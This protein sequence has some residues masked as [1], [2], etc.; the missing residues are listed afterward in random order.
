MNK[1]FTKEEIK[2]TIKY[3]KNNKSTG[4]DG[5]KAELL[6]HAPEI[7]C[8][9]IAEIAEIFNEAAKSGDYP[10]EL[11]Q[12]ILTKIQKR[13]KTKGPITNLRPITLLRKILASCMKQR[14]IDRIDREIPPSQTAYRAGRSTTEHVFAMKI[15]A[16]K[17]ITSQEYTIF[18]LILD[19]SKAFD[20]VNR[21]LLI[22]DLSKIIKRDELHIISIMLQV[23]LSVKCGSSTSEFFKTDTGVPQ[24]DGLSANQ[25]TL[26][27]ANT[28]KNIQRNEN[29]YAIQQ[30]LT[31]TQ[32]M[33]CRNIRG[34][35]CIFRCQS[36]SILD[37]DTINFC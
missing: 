29:D 12:G 33:H 9:E 11:T 34:I 10:K 26:Y 14:I 23:E 18:L 35:I 8:T 7:V 6:K 13:G 31:L 17:T 30:P 16:E 4:N 32:I 20:T 37:I 28:L 19:M 22:E 25:F 2:N 27:L 36:I 5:V 1:P 3:L 15:L 21:K 24:G